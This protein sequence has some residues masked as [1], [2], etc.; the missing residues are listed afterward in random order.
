MKHNHKVLALFFATLTLLSSCYYDKEDELYDEYYAQNSCDTVGVSYAQDIAPVI[1]GKCATTGCH[2]AGGS[3][4]GIF[5]NYNGVKAKVD[6][7]SFLN[8]TTVTM[9]MPPS[10]PLSACQIKLVQSWIAA[11][12]PNN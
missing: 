4:P 10:A 7:G 3:G 6:N 5:D 2:V 12:A 1:A 8:R 9:D 11:G